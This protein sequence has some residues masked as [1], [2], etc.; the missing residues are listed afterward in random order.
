M[1]DSKTENYRRIPT[2]EERKI[3][4]IVDNNS[5]ISKAVRGEFDLGS[6]VTVLKT[7][8]EF[9]MHPYNLQR[10]QEMIPDIY[11]PRLNFAHW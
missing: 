1:C 9:E 5:I 2:M 3:N 6:H 11:L 8:L 7:L 10:M 4:T